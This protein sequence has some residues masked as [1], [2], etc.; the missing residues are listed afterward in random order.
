MKPRIKEMPIQA[1][2]VGGS[3]GVFAEEVGGEVEVEEGDGEEGCASRTPSS[4]SPVG[5]RGGGEGEVSV[6][7]ESGRTGPGIA[8]M[9]GA[10]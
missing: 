10:S 8:L 1:W 7:R 9:G 5:V 4:F 6:A 3:V 2:G